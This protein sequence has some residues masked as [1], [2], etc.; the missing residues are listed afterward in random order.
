MILKCVLVN[1]NFIML[2]FCHSEFAILVS[3]ANEVSDQLPSV[4]HL[5]LEIKPLF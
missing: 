5:I 1:F 3:G 4:K 2:Y